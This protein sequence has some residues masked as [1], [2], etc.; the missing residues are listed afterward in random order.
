MF[1]VAYLTIKRWRKL[2]EYKLSIP[3]G[4]LYL[5]EFNYNY[6]LINFIF[7]P[8]ILICSFYKFICKF[9]GALWD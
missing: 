7:F 5:Y 4:D 1:L 6:S 9:G 2:E 8:S 3:Q